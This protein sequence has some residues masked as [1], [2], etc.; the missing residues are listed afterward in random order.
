MSEFDFSDLS[1]IE[2]PVS[3]DGKQYFLR[4]AD[5][6]AEAKF[7]NAL[8]EGVEIGPEGKPVRVR[9]SA[10]A[11]PLLVHLC[12]WDKAYPEGRRVPLDRVKAW[13]SRVVRKLFNKA[14]EISE[15]QTTSDKEDPS[16][17]EPSGTTGGSS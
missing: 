16:G 5:G 7:R 1:V 11:E 6:E 4:E 3:I 9:G 2:I 13:P 10:D 8:M 14:K 15:I 17:N 12:L